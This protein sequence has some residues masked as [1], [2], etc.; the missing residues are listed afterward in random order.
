MYFAHWQK[1]KSLAINTICLSHIRWNFALGTDHGRKHANTTSRKLDSSSVFSHI[2]CEFYFM[3]NGNVNVS[4]WCLTFSFRIAIWKLAMPKCD[5]IGRTRLYYPCV[6]RKWISSGILGGFYAGDLDDS[7]IKW[8][9]R[10]EPIKYVN[11][12]LF[13]SVY[14]CVIVLRLNFFL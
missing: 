6:S 11:F 12:R 13:Q 14:K 5:G 8:C 7:K 3:E 1:T 10:N 4:L 2:P 9:T